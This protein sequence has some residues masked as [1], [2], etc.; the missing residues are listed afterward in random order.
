MIDNLSLH[1][2]PPIYIDSL[3]SSLPCRIS[4]VNFDATTSRKLKLYAW[5]ILSGLTWNSWKV[6][7]MVGNG[8]IGNWTCWRICWRKVVC[9]WG[10]YIHVIT[11][12]VISSDRVQICTRLLHLSR[13]LAGAQA[14][15]GI[16][17]GGG[18]TTFP[19]SRCLDG[20]F[21]AFGRGEAR[22]PER[23]HFGM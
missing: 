2:P 23:D 10:L 11:V 19:P 22:S 1:S 14:E 18:A 8:S 16:L 3:H 13:D 7:G 6:L 17:A 4:Y 15:R 21:V 5:I 9:V 12:L 20:R